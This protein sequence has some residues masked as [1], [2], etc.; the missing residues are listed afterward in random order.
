MALPADLQP[1]DALI[2]VLV[3]ALVREAERGEGE[4]PDDGKGRS[5]A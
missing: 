1:Y 3:E 2:T 4:Q 5:D